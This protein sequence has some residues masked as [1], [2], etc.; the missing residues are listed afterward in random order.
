MLWLGGAVREPKVV[1]NFCSQSDFAAT[2]LAQLG[3]DISRFELSRN[4][5]APKVE[6]FGYYTFNNGFGVVQADGATIYDCTTNR[7]ISDDVS[8]ERE[9]IG[10]TMLQST[11]R[12]I[13]EL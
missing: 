9:Y 3:C 6:E 11:Y 7:V 10:K 8:P 4:I 12:L 2:L 5:F 13:D 1:E